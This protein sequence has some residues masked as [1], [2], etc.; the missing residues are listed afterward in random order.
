[1]RRYHV[2]TAAGEGWF[3]TAAAE[4]ERL[5]PTLHLICGL[6]C[7]GKTTL[8]RE[9]EREYDALRLTPDDWVM[10]MLGMPAKGTPLGE[11]QAIRNPIETLLFDHALR[12]L[13]LDVDV[14]LDFGVWTRSEREEFR[15]RAAAVGARTELHF[16]DAPED[17]LL[18]RL[19]ERNAS[20]PPGT[21]WLDPAWMRDWFHM[22]ERPTADELQPR[23][24]PRSRQGN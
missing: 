19:A 4:S 14:I 10:A 8:A 16:T 23:D 24:A 15:A 17:V 2:P 18:A 5:I 13:T 7:S 9:L 1:M 12:L 22:I 3:P 21:F 20:L 6:P 11:L